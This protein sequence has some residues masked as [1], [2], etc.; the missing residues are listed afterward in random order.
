MGKAVNYK[1]LPHILID[2][3]IPDHFN[4]PLNS[5]EK[6]RIMKISGTYSKGKD[7]MRSWKEDSNQKDEAATAEVKSASNLFLSDSF[8]ELEK[9]QHS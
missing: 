8:I 4:I 2:S 6:D 1:S 5:D 9:F 3:I 7:Q